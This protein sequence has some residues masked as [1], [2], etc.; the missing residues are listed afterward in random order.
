MTNIFL[1]ERGALD[2]LCFSVPSQPVHVDERVSVSVG[3]GCR[4]ANAKSCS[5]SEMTV[6][7]SKSVILCISW[8]LK[9]GAC[10]RASPY[11]ESRSWGGGP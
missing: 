5:Q 1:E 10:V 11:K 2:R 3:V 9:C 4:Q 7:C 6:A 8:S